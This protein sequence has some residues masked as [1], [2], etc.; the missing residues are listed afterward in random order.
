M[1][2]HLPP[3]L[4]PGVGPGL[5]AAGEREK[6]QN[7]FLLAFNVCFFLKKKKKIISPPLFPACF[8]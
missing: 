8:Y 5:A 6:D 4:A 1:G 3:H 7:A 2:K